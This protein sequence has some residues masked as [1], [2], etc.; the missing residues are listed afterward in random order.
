MVGAG[1]PAAVRT[2]TGQ[3]N[4]TTDSVT[5][6]STE[7]M[8]AGTGNTRS[9]TTFE[10]AEARFCE[11]RVRTMYATATPGCDLVSSGAMGS[12]KRTWPSARETSTRTAGIVST[13]RD[14][15]SSAEPSDL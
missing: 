14:D 2:G 15:V 12:V 8:G 4:S 5:R 1:S 6:A 9:E 13:T 10:S 3:V 11:A 7:A